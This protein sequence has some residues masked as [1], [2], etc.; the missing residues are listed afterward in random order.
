L[1]FITF[2]YI[3]FTDITADTF[4][5]FIV[6]LI[7]Y[8]AL[9]YCYF[10]FINLSVTAR[11]IRIVRD[12]YKNEEGMTKS[13]I[14][15]VYNASVMVDNRVQRMINSGQ[16]IIKDNML[17]IGKPILLLIAKIIVLLKFII[18]GSKSLDETN[19]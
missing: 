2:S 19:K 13:E 17:Y 14:L 9:S 18:L 4:Y 15:K 8:T 16:I 6:D 10:H 12:L 3:Y 7:I 1:F 5:I 11:R